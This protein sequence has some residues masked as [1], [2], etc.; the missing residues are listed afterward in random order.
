MGRVASW[1]HLAGEGVKEETWA[2][3]GC[4]TRGPCDDYPREL[5]R[6]KLPWGFKSCPPY[7]YWKSGR[8]PCVSTTGFR[9]WPT[10]SPVS[11]VSASPPCPSRHIDETPPPANSSG[12]SG[13]EGPG[14]RPS[15]THGHY[16]STAGP[17]P[18]CPSW[19]Q[20]HPHWHLGL[21]RVENFQDFS[22]SLS[23]LGLCVGCPPS[24]IKPSTHCL[25][26]NTSSRLRPNITTSGGL[27]YPLVAG[28]SPSHSPAPYFYLDFRTYHL[29][30]AR[31]DYLRFPAN[32]A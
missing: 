9:V 32:G 16:M 30:N 31:G 3:G 11:L 19:F 8:L 13:L 17:L 25:L 21:Q 26:T 2:T 4:W 23:L 12:P 14:C 15:R 5:C 24:G 1:A 29:D 22:G 28:A 18:P 27:S 7:C 6:M 10:A 20:P